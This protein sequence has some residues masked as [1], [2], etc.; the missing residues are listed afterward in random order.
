MEHQW[1]TQEAGEKERLPAPLDGELCPYPLT[2]EY[3]SY[4]LTGQHGCTREACLY[5]IHA[6]R[7]LARRIQELAALP[8]RT[9]AQE[10]RFLGLKRHYARLLEREELP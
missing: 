8:R 4:R 7:L 1:N 3:E 5:R 9:P 2:C 6:R 10:E